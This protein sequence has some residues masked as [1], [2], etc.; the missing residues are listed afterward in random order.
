M[1]VQTTKLLFVAEGWRK[2]RLEAEVNMVQHRVVVGQ[3]TATEAAGGAPVELSASTTKEARVG[4]SGAFLELLR[5]QYERDQDVMNQQEAAVR[6]LLGH[7]TVREGD[8][9]FLGVKVE[10]GEGGHGHGWVVV[11]SRQPGEAPVLASALLT[12][13]EAAQE[14]ARL[15]LLPRPALARDL[16]WGLKA[17][18]MAGPALWGARTIEH[19]GGQA[20]YLD[21]VWDRQGFVGPPEHTAPLMEA[22][23][24]TERNAGALRSFV[25]AVAKRK[26][27][28]PDRARLLEPVTYETKGVQF[29]A[30]R[31]E[32]GGY[33]YLVARLTPV[34]VTVEEA[35]QALQVQAA[36]GVA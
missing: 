16:T 34:P 32:S 18:W 8:S 30:S 6:D 3:V 26:V 19:D 1:K 36:T 29:H 10:D 14:V 31:Q 7:W 17:S 35:Q 2:V 33:V 27:H 21:V 25:A 9:P 22:L 5:Q 24:G 13:E 11:H 23:N 12:R 20:D 4:L 28:V 15:N